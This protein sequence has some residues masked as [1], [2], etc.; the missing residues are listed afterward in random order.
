[1]PEYVLRP[2]PEPCR[3]WCRLEDGRLAHPFHGMGGM[4]TNDKG[5]DEVFQQTDF[6]LQ[7][8]SIVTVDESKGEKRLRVGEPRVGEWWAVL[9]CEIHEPFH[10]CI[11]QYQEK[12]ELPIECYKYPDRLRCGCLV[13]TFEPGAMAGPRGW[14]G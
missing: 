12:R 13:P 6:R 10:P 5:E 4:G 8:G 7:D 14:Q 1:M 9:R 11:F 3:D 2:D